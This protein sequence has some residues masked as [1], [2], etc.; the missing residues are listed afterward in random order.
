NTEPANLTE[1]VNPKTGRIHGRFNQTGAITGR[2]SM[3]DPNLQ[4]IP[5]RTDEGRRIRLAF[6]AGG[7]DKVLLTA[8]YS[9][10][11]LRVLAH[12]TEEPALL[13]AFE[14]DED[15]HKAVASDVFNVPREA[16]SKGQRGQAKTIHYGIIY[17]VSAL[18][19]PR[20]SEGLV[21]TDAA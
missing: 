21:V 12:F 16:V 9:Q 19:L 3:S 2:L 18:R 6:V 11:E 15:I 14:A 10:I 7:A 1:D 5:I 17:E 8:D 13:R 4:N 20:R